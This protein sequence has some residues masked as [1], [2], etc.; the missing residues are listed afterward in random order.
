MAHFRGPLIVSGATGFVGRAL[1]AK[2]GADVV[3]LSMRSS[4]WLEA[5]RSMPLEGATLFH[6]AARVHETRTPEQQFVHDNVDKTRQLAELAATRGAHR[7]VFLSTAKIHGEES[8]A[9]P[10]APDDI[11]APADAYSRSKLAAEVALHEV[12]LRHSLEVVSVR[13]PLVYGKGAA[14]NARALM[15][16]AD[17]SW[18]LPFAEVENRRSFVHVDDLADLLVLCGASPQA[19]G[20]AY[21]A[22]HRLPASTRELIATTRAC[23]GRPARL[24]A[25]SP[26]VLE[27]AATCVGQGPRMKKLTRSL[28]VDSSA[29]TR[30]LGW[31]AHKGLADAV[32]DLVSE[33]A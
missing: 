28:E 6:L 8:G 10:F 25:V 4:G 3:P 15:R 9:R 19:A 17:S 24:F 32:A 33:R 14:G 27:A 22:G 1:C 18:P 26:S 5:A 23:L 11:P 2:L 21:L 29:A 12:A 7:L 30:D 20:H 16:L 31:E 13:S